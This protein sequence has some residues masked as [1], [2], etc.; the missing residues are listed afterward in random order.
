MSAPV[1][2]NY[3]VTPTLPAVPAFASSPTREP[4]L[5]LLIIN[6]LFRQNITA[7]ILFIACSAILL[8]MCIILQGYTADNED[9]K[10]KHKE[11]ITGGIVVASLLLVYA[12][13]RFLFNFP[14]ISC[15]VD[16]LL[17]VMIYKP[18]YCDG[19]TW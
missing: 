10:Q 6:K 9:E 5:P 13:I 8:R 18:N 12:L 2:Y 15:P 17:D 7:I 19:P 1:T 3:P 4:V 11:I 14:I 16:K